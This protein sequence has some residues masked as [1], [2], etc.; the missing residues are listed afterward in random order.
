ML[1]LMYSYLTVLGPTEKPTPISAP[2]LW[3]SPLLTTVLRAASSRIS[4]AESKLKVLPAAMLAPVAWISPSVL[5]R[6]TLRRP[7]NRASL[8]LRIASVVFAV[9]G[10]EADPNFTLDQVA[11][12]TGRGTHY[13]VTIRCR[14]QALHGL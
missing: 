10:G 14:C 3:L 1:A 5:V 12:A 13:L 7:L 9:G 4:R 8:G 11:A 6:V 2:A